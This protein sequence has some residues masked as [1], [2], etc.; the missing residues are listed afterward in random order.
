[1]IE[2]SGFSFTNSATNGTVSD[3]APMMVL[4]HI[5]LLSATDLEGVE[6]IITRLQ[7]GV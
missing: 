4:A 2:T 5:V 6:V 3:I 1:M 7:G